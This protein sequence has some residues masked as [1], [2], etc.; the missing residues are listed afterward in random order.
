MVIISNDVVEIR[1]SFIFIFFG[2]SFC[3]LNAQVLF[4][5]WPFCLS[6][7]SRVHYSYLLAQWIHGHTYP[8]SGKRCEQ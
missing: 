7:G 5:V 3:V 1:V 8:L 6:L 4:C 2:M